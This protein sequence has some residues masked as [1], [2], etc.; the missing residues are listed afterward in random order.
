MDV[1]RAKTGVYHV[2]VDIPVFQR[3][4]HSPLIVV[5]RI[6]CDRSLVR[7]NFATFLEDLSNSFHDGF[8]QALFLAITKD[9]DMHDV[10]LLSTTATLVKPCMTPWLVFI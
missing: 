5:A 10:M 1:A 7:R 4:Q 3:T 9:L 8:E 2:S 6:R